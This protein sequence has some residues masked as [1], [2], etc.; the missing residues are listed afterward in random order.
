MT[1]TAYQC[2]HCERLAERGIRSGRPPYHGPDTDTRRVALG[3]RVT[4]PAQKC[5]A[6][7]NYHG[8]TD[9][10]GTV[11]R[12]EHPF[13]AGPADMGVPRPYYVVD[14]SDGQVVYGESQLI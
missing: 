2:T 9:W 12:F 8:I 14:M 4:V 11:I 13:H 5:P 6:C 7:D 3:D 1:T 10:R